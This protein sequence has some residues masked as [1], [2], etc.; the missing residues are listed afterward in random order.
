MVGSASLHQDLVALHNTYPSEFRS[1][2]VPSSAYLS[3]LSLGQQNFWADLVFIWSIQYFDRYAQSVRDTYL[4]HTYDVITDLNPHFYEAYIFG[5][6]FLSLDKRWDLIYKLADKGL[7]KN[8]KNWLIAWD[9]GTYAFF[10]QKDYAVALK[11]FHIAEERNPGD[12]RLKDF[13]ANAY[14]YRGDY[15][16]SLLYWENLKASNEKNETEQGHFFTFAAEKNIFDLTIKID[17]RDLSAAVQ[18]YRKARGT[19]PPTLPALVTAGF[20]KALP[21]DPEGKPYLYDHT[22]GEVSC[23]TPFKFRGKFAQW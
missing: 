1:Y 14:K 17:L 18:A 13:L 11:Y 3:V 21:V 10:Q 22:T 15:E 5:D 12:P 19:L 20:L 7:E 2:Y 4:F 8:P 6:L 9:A 23:Q 16:R